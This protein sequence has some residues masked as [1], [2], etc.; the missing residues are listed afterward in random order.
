MTKPTLQSWFS[1][2]SIH[3]AGD[4]DVSIAQ[5]LCLFT[6]LLSEF[7]LPLVWLTMTFGQGDAFQAA[8]QGLRK[9]RSLGGKVYPS[10]SECCNSHAV[11]ALRLRLERMYIAIASNEPTTGFISCG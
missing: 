5:S 6:A 1:R 8:D 7:S 3:K 9:Q 11:K 2:D 10:N 4:L